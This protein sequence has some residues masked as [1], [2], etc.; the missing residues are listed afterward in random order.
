MPAEFVVQIFKTAPLQKIIIK[1]ILNGKL[2]QNFSF[3]GII[4]KKYIYSYLI[5]G[6][7]I[8]ENP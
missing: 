7:P 4:I 1:K 3:I 2:F 5:N 8:A 6:V